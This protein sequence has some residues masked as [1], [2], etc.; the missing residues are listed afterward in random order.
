MLKDGE[1]YDA[2]IV[3]AKWDESKSGKMY[4]N[5]AADVYT[6]RNTVR[7]YGS[8]W[9]TPATTKP[10]LNEDSSE[11]PSMLESQLRACG[12]KGVLADAINIG[13]G[14]DLTGN[15]CRVKIED[16]EYN[17]KVTQRIAMFYTT[18]SRCDM[19]KLADLLGAPKSNLGDETFEEEDDIF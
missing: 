5:V 3:S 15:R 12:F 9:A 2:E 6:D 11:G 1:F 4:L 7:A 16:N 10:R 8:I 14:I 13:D 19:N 18:A 17:G